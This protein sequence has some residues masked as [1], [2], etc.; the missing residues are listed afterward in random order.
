MDITTDEAQAMRRTLADA[1]QAHHVA[2][3]AT[4]AAALRLAGT[5]HTAER[6]AL[7]RTVA[8][9]VRR[10]QR[11]QR[12]ASA[13]WDAWDALEDRDGFRASDSDG[14]VIGEDGRLR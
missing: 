6:A 2:M 9:A 8:Q 12:D 5:Q 11:R 13:A 3:A 7:L 4:D 1:L 14:Y 10:E